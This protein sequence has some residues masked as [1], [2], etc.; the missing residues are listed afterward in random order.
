MELKLKDR[1]VPFHT[2]NAEKI[3]Q[4]STQPVGL[5]APWTIVKRGKGSWRKKRRKDIALKAFNLKRLKALSLNLQQ[6]G[7]AQSARGKVFVLWNGC[8]LREE[9]AGSEGAQGGRKN[10]SNKQKQIAQRSSEETL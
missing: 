6:Q 5:K 1:H 3:Q 2:S 8:L 4:M 9:A 7:L 10:L